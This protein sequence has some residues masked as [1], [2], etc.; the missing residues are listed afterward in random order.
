[1][2]WATDRHLGLEV[3][4]LNFAVVIA[5]AMDGNGSGLEALQTL[6][7]GSSFVFQFTSWAT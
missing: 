2:D 6:V 1:M 5:I 7:F 4:V 3:D